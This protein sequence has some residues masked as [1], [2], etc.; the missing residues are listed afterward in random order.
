[1]WKLDYSRLHQ[2][3]DFNM[4]GGLCSTFLDSFPMNHTSSIS[5]TPRGR[6][7]RFRYLRFLND[8]ASCVTYLEE[9]PD[10]IVGTTT[11]GRPTKAVVVVVKF[12]TRYGKAMA[13]LSDENLS[14][15]TWPC[16]KCP[17][18]PLLAFRY[19]TCGC[20]G[21]HRNSTPPAVNCS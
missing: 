18:R 21:L 6:V 17:I 16:S 4:T 3:E 11:G 2:D 13:C 8:V 9:I 14:Y 19:Y 15:V 7:V 1:M 5:H 10:N 20:D 12:V